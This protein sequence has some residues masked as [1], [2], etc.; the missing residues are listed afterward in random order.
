MTPLSRLSSQATL[1]SMLPSLRQQTYLHVPDFG[2]LCPPL[3]WQPRLHDIGSK[4]PAT[5]TGLSYVVRCRRTPAGFTG[6]SGVLT[7]TQSHLSCIVLLRACSRA[8]QNKRT[9]SSCLDSL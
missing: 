5:S 6:P 3:A 2:M 4:R 7:I 9:G 1:T 8:E